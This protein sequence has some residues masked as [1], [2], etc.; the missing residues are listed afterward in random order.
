MELLTRD[1]TD[2]VGF[3]TQPSIDI[4]G[5][6]INATHFN[7]SLPNGSTRET[8]NTYRMDWTADQVVWYVNGVQLANTSTNIPV[9]PS[10]VYINMWG[11]F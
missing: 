11:K 10:L 6:Y 7:E 8:W 2:I 3:N 4:H 9:E 5:D 1:A